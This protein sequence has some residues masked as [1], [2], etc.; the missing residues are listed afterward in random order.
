[1]SGNTCHI[2]NLKIDSNEL[3]LHFLEVHSAEN[4]CD[5]CK[6]TFQNDSSLK[7]HILKSHKEAKE[8]KCDICEKV[9]TTK[10]TLNL[11]QELMHNKKE[12]H[13]NQNE[14]CTQAAGEAF[15]LPSK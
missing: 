11:H 15:D 3:E 9:L 1:M 4:E 6:K 12:T 2:C 10:G 14:E 13:Q 7:R 8:F 5:L